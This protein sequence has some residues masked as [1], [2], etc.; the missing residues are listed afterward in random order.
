MDGLHTVALRGLC[1]SHFERAVLPVFK[2]LREEQEKLQAQ[3]KELQAQMPKNMDSRACACPPAEAGSGVKCHVDQYCVDGEERVL[4]HQVDGSLAEHMAKLVNQFGSDLE[5]KLEASVARRMEELTVSV[6]KQLSDSTA[7][8]V[9]RTEELKEMLARKADADQVA[10]SAQLKGQSN[11]IQ[12]L[13]QALER[14]AC[15]SKVPTLAQLHDLAAIVDGKANAK[16][17]PTLLSVS[18]LTTAMERKADTSKVPS[19]TQYKRLTEMVEAKADANKVPSVAQLNDLNASLKRKANVADVPTVKQFEA[20]A[21]LLKQKASVDDVATAAQVEALATALEWKADVGQPFSIIGPPVLWDWDG[22][23]AVPQMPMCV[24]WEVPAE[25][26]GMMN[27]ASNNFQ[28]SKNRGSVNRNQKPGKAFKNGLGMN[29]HMTGD[30]NAPPDIDRIVADIVMEQSGQ[31]AYQAH[32]APSVDAPKDAPGN[33]QADAADPSTEAEED[34]A[35]K[36]TG[37]LCPSECPEKEET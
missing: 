23:N 12:K 21:A 9:A 17:V 37:E 30:V 34:P 19:F 5:S 7:A 29:G 11:A 25:Q 3:L 36:T 1:V 28:K 14:K 31:G 35:D 33:W 18:E 13:S 2:E 22:Q 32:Q 8:S 10:S 24:P 4:P 15:A 6:E 16:N 20:L 26:Q 27:Q